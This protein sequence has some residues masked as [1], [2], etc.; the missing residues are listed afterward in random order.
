MM[1]GPAK[2][3]VVPIEFISARPPAAPIPERKR[4]GIVQMIARAVLVPTTAAVRP[5][6]EMTSEFAQTANRR[7]TPETRQVEARPAILRPL[8][9]IAVAQKIMTTQAIKLGN[10]VRKPTAK[11]EKF[12][13]LKISGRKRAT[14]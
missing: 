3:P 9:P 14:P 7:P 10:A 11:L 4:A 5:M 6:K 2:P 8:R 13:P 12:W 1:D